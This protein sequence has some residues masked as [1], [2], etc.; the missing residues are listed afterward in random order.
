MRLVPTPTPAIMLAMPVRRTVAMVVASSVAWSVALSVTSSISGSAVAIAE[1]G[2]CHVVDIAFKPTLRPDL[3]PARNPWPQIVVWLEDAEGKFVQTLFITKETGSHGLGNRPG[4]WDFNSGP[5][6]PYGRRINTFPVWAHR[7]GYEWDLVVF[8][9]D[10]DNNLSHPFNESS[11]DQHYCRPMLTSEPAWDALTCASPNQVYTDK[12]KLSSSM[13]SKYPPR[14]DIERVPGTDHASVD[15]F[16]PN[17]LDAVSQPTPKPDVSNPAAIAEINWPIP[18]DLP[19]GDY[20]VWVE[21]SK[22]FDHNETYSVSRYPAPTGIPWADYGAPYRGQPSVVYKVP[23]TIDTELKIAQTT[24]YAGYGD[25]DGMNG[26]LRAPDDTITT[27]LTGSGLGRLAV[28]TD[29]D[30][31]YRVRVTARPEFDSVV[32]AAPGSI[33]VEDTTSSSATVSFIV[34]G[35]DGHT[36]R[37]SGYD[38][39]MR[40]G[41][42]ITA[43]NFDSSPRANEIVIPVTDPGT[44]ARFRVERL[45]P[46]TLYSVGIRAYDD[47]HNTGELTV[48]SFTTLERGRGE[49][50][51]CFIATAAYGSVLA[52]DVEMLRHLR[53]A[54][55]EKS[56]LGS[57]A[58]QTYYTFSPALAGVISESELLRATAR[59]VLAPIVRFVRAFRL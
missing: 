47:C 37:I 40:L 48:V 20:V 17:P 12:G 56:V 13:K 33:T 55:L 31:A 29:A 25:P 43:E 34:P 5:L 53:D 58:V 2:E 8:Q 22:E 6:W 3:P 51:A 27:D 1:P 15:R 19:P 57:L 9:N 44:T 10:D 7:H 24:D 42:E 30:G 11:K 46:E 16:S 39:R 41:E 32:P 18:E 49:V 50:D 38:I 14:S 54:V 4:R 45:L 59:E 23:F 26:D 35:D 36:G 52:A 28:V 21:V